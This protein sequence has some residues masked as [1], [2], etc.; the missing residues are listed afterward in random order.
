MAMVHLWIASARD[1]LGLAIKRARRAL[2][3]AFR[4]GS[5]VIYVA[6]MLVFGVIP[7]LLISPTTHSKNPWVEVG[8]LASRLA[9]AGLLSLFGLII[10]L[11]ALTIKTQ[12][13]LANSE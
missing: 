7:Y 6:G 8:L 11:G 2:A 12:E 4:P 9:A 3:N 1:G 13:P 10:T 5:V